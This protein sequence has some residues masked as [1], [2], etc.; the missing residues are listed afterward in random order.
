MSVHF[1]EATATLFTTTSG[2]RSLRLWDLTVSENIQASVTIIVLGQIVKSFVRLHKCT[3]AIN[4]RCTR[5]S[6]ATRKKE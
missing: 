1:D 4:K 5:W 3:G 2:D 6:S